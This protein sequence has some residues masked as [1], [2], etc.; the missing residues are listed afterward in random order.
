MTACEPG[1][2]RLRNVVCAWAVIALLASHASTVFAGAVTLAGTAGAGGA[3]K[4]G[5]WT[6]V[7]VT[8]EASGEDAGGLLVVRWGDASVERPIAVPAGARKR[9]EFYLHTMDVAAAVS[10]ML[11][12]E[13]QSL[14]STELPLRTVP[15]EAPFT[16]CVTDEGAGADTATDCTGKTAAAA[17]PRS[18]RGYDAIDRVDWRGGSEET[19]PVDQRL[20]FARWRAMRALDEAG[21]LAATDRPPSIMAALARKN[22]AAPQVRITIGAFLAL[23]V[24]VAAATRRRRPRA[25]YAGVLISIACGVGGAMAAGR[26][27]P[28]SAVVIHHATLV[29]QL[30]G[31]GGSLVSM[32]GAAEFPAYDEYAVQATLADAAI[33]TGPHQSL[34]ENGYPVLE[35]TFGTGARRAFTLDA[36]TDIRPLLITRHGTV[37]RVANVSAAD[38][39]DCRFADGSSIATLDVLRAGSAVE[40]QLRGAIVGPVVTCTMPGLPVEFAEARHA[41][42]AQGRTLVVAYVDPAGEGAR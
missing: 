20:A 35:G 40:T 34:E 30:P 28:G 19:L 2:T 37:V 27:G 36:A 39:R 7:S 1:T 31:P 32:R 3:S 18:V 26:T 6:P 9:F 42:R 33:E 23:L 41:V 13:G 15:A 8:V 11:L 21:S 17:L 16:L 29:Q 22:R 38:L 12:R 5:R 4:P 25:V 10:V 14:A 24:T